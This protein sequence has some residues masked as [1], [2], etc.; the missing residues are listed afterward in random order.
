M[1]SPSFDVAIIGGGPAGAT[2]GTLLRKYMPALSVI[3]IE[4]ETFPREHVGESQ[5]PLISTILDEMGVWD[6]VEAANF[7]IKVGATYTWGRDPAPWDFNFVPP[8]QFR[9]EERPAKFEGQRRYT[10]FQVDR[11]I[12]DD[13]LLRHAQSLGCEVREGTQVV[14]VMRDG[15]RVEGL[16]LSSGETITARYYIDA[17]GTVGLVRRTFDIPV[18]SP[19][20]L[21]NVAFWDYWENA[22]WAEE[23]GIGGTRVQVRSLPYGWLWFIPLGPT[24]TS[25]GLVC[26]AEH[27][28]KSGKRPEEIYRQALADESL[29]ASLIAEATP[30]GN[31]RST[32]DWSFVAERL[33]GENWFLIGEA[34]GF[35]DPILAAGLTLAHTSAR[36]A[37]YTIM[38]LERGEHERDWLLKRFDDKNRES[39]YHHI[40]FAIY[41][42]SANGL[43]SDL[44]EYCQEL[45]ASAGLRL[46]PRDAFQWISQGAFTTE[47]VG[48]PSISFYD[49]T[50]IHDL[51]NRFGK[52]NR[53]QNWLIDGF[54]VFDLNLH[55]ASQ[56]FVGDL[57]NGRIRKV[58]CYVKGERKLPLHEF[59]GLVVD[60]LRQSNDA[61]TILNLTNNAIEMIFPPAHHAYARSRVL[62][63]LESLVLEGW[64][65]AKHNRKRQPLRLS[66]RAETITSKA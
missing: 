8:E 20:R 2:A 46:N 37:A 64:V 1:S 4:K 57:A 32:K 41:W 60:V 39:I 49:L 59:Y 47:I 30:E 56:S 62:E 51:V 7:P 21:R 53:T 25:I 38:E 16:R 35:A 3:I 54:S 6:K 10:A 66:P 29:I 14:E 48:N 42:Y 43:Q 22:E 31:V 40:R 34:A 63:V 18:D 50:S 28:K 36:D 45:A 17:S 9:D 33:C 23:I 24:R 11:A 5:L 61:M 55:N 44:Q 52:G 65:I 27:Y 15:D 12:Y 26:H 19:E 58:P 13:I